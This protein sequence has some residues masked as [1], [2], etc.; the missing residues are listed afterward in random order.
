MVCRYAGQAVTPKCFADELQ[1]LLQTPITHA[2]VAQAI[3]FL[4]DSLLIY[5][6]PPL[7]MLQ[8]KQA[9][10]PKLCVCD[11]F[12]RDGVLQE[13]LPLDPESLKGCTQAVSTQV[14]HVIESVLGYFLKGVPGLEVSWFPQRAK[15]PELD[16]VLTIGTSRIPVEVKYRRGL[17]DKAA[18]A[19]IESFCDKAAYSAP[20]GVVVTQTAEGPIGDKAIAVPASSMLLLK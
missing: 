15:E 6:I 2:K 8:K 3:Q 5:C 11:H 19:G 14:G 10:P 20:F 7:E 17:R 1:E 18:I 4:A 9:H 13:T 12:V 16:F